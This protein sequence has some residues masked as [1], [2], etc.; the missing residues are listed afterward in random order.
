MLPRQCYLCSC[1]P[2]SRRVHPVVA[3]EAT[4]GE[5][6][7]AANNTVTL[8]SLGFTLAPR[9]RRRGVGLA[10]CDCRTVQSAF[11]CVMPTNTQQTPTN[12]S[13]L[14]RNCHPLTQWRVTLLAGCIE[15]ALQVA[16]VVAVRQDTRT[17]N[18]GARQGPASQDGV[19][20]SQI[21]LSREIRKHLGP[22]TTHKL[23]MPTKQA[24]D[25]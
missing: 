8:G 21:A 9:R 1:R 2:V 7:V 13:H 11:R 15:V 12:A 23:H 3:R 17:Q 4:G 10:M 16:V 6:T 20:D 5:P 14:Y 24:W 19:A 22:I 18:N 25:E